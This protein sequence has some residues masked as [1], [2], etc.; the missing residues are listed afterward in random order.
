L[1][2][3]KGKNLDLLKQKATIKDGSQTKNQY[4]LTEKQYNKFHGKSGSGEGRGSLSPVDKGKVLNIVITVLT[5][6]ALLSECPA[7]AYK[8][9]PHVIA[10][11][12]L[13]ITRGFLFY[14]SS[15]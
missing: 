11:T 7:L 13:Q 4:F 6:I 3:A 9:H 12:C 14:V 1:V 5:A 15:I 8:Q 2:V 10:G